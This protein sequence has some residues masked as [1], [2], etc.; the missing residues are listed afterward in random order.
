MRSDR[1]SGGAPTAR[2]RPPAAPARDPVHVSAYA[3]YIE[4]LQTT[5]AKPMVKQHL[6]AIRMLFDSII[7]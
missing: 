5:A 4:A 3:A 6:A 7:G 2:S 1:L